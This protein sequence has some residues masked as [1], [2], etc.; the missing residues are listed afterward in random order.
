MTGCMLTQHVLACTAGPN[1]AGGLSRAAIT[2]DIISPSTSS[3]SAGQGTSSSSRIS[4]AAAAVIGV[5]AGVIVL[6][7]VGF[8]VA[9]HR[10][11]QQQSAEVGPWYEVGRVRVLNEGGHTTQAGYIYDWWCRRQQ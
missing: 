4:V 8:A 11:R 7:V 10:S 1:A 5:L 2:S 3:G 6:A 9:K